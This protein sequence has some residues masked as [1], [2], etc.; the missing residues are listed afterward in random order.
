MQI[1][2]KRIKNVLVLSIF[3]TLGFYFIG[4]YFGLK[5]FEYFY[6]NELFKKIENLYL[7]AKNLNEE[8]N[9]NKEILLLD[10]LNRDAKCKLLERINNKVRYYSFEVLAKQLPY[11]LE[12]YDSK[13]RS[14]SEYLRLKR[15][16]M[17]LLSTSYFL[18]LKYI[19][20]CNKNISTIL[21]VYSAS[22]GDICIK[23]GEELDK[24]KEY[25][26]DYY[27]F[28]IDKEL[29]LSEIEIINEMYEIYSVPTIVING[30]HILRGFSNISL[31][32]SSLN[33]R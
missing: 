4:I 14:S 30:K 33:E 17:K 13:Y 27:F 31:I 15:E 28:I 2:K 19:E 5:I 16:Y 20:D 8:I 29:N 23:Q 9:T 7:E 18:T 3:L 24:V 1:A 22:C 21:Y 6:A 12:E 10:F 26:L 32:L 11:R 25:N